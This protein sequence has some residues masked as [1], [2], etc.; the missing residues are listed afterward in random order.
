MADPRREPQTEEEARELERYLQEGA[1]TSL[2][3]VNTFAAA[4][5]PDLLAEPVSIAFDV[6]GQELLEQLT[7]DDDQVL[8]D[9][10]ISDVS[11]TDEP[12]LLVFLNRPAAT[13]E[14]PATDPGFV[15]AIA[16]FMPHGGVRTR[17]NAT[18]AVGNA[19]A[20]PLPLAVTL[21]PVSVP[22]SPA[23]AAS[24]VANAQIQLVRSTVELPQ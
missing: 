14:T 15:G 3:V 2:E 7:T 16:F 9:I 6:T 17:F 21:I 10:E 19:A 8:L 22:E 4:R 24:R 1:A 23:T 12:P 20:T 11:P 13:A 5:L 18:E